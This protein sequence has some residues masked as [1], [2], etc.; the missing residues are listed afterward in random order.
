MTVSLVCQTAFPLLSDFQL[1]I[2]YT[3]PISAYICQDSCLLHTFVN[4]RVII[5]GDLRFLLLHTKV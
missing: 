1:L 5:P 3:I 4:P 2:P